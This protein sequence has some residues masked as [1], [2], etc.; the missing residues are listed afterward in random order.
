MAAIYDEHGLHSDRPN[1]MRT[2]CGKKIDPF[3]MVPA[4]VE[5][6]DISHSLARQCR[7]N[8]H[9]VGHLSVAR[10]SLWVTEW[11][12]RH[13]PERTNYRERVQ[14]QLAALLHDAAEAYIGDMIRPLKHRPEFAAFAGLDELVTGVIYAKAKLPYLSLPA[15]VHE[16]DNAIGVAEVNILRYEYVTGNVAQDYK[17]FS[18]KL[19][20]L[21]KDSK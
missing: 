11:V 1:A 21:L 18:Y 19:G 2:F 4:D 14:M 13:L 8:G 9:T 7:F 16:G 15:L 6:E 10:H 17:D 3:D 20:I 5:W 12:N